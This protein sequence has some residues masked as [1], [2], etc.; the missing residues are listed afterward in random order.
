M[1]V[2]LIEQLRQVQD[3]RTLIWTKTSTLVSVAVRN[4][5]NH[6]RVCWVPCM[7]RLCKT[8]SLRINRDV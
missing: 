7:G 1:D 5:G 6:E 8:A 2:N 4:N 3:F